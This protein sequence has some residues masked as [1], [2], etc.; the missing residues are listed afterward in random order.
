MTGKLDPNG[1]R[2]TIQ[3]GLSLYVAHYIGGY[4][5]PNFDVSK[6]KKATRL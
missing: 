1:V 5:G 4:Q 2:L 6:N 3:L